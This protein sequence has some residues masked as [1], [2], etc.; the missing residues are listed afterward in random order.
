VENRR[1]GRTGHYSSIVTLGCFSLASVTQ[2]E[3]DKTIELALSHGVN[4]FDVAPAYGEAELRL[5]PWMKDHRDEIFLACKTTKRTKK[6]AAEVL[7]QSLERTGAE[8]FDLYQ[9]HALDEMD[10]LRRVFGPKGALQAML[11]AR[12]SGIIRYIGITS[13]RPLIMLE[14]LKLFDFDSVMLP[15]SFVLKKHYDARSDYEP[16]LRIAKQ[17]DIGTI[18]MKSFAKQPYQTEKRSHATYYEPFDSQEDIEK[19]VNFALS[20]NVTT[21]AS[22]S[23]IKLIPKILRAAERHHELTEIEL[24][25]II[26]SAANLKPIFPDGAFMDQLTTW[27]KSRGDD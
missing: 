13:H 27:R 16:I 11:E 22:A 7:R 8:Y 3:A 24:A 25:K 2:A 6:S 15:I 21:V 10:E 19:C 17:R 5:R 1:L 26:E 9:V 4:H 20:Q 23:D 18:A 14:A 12:R